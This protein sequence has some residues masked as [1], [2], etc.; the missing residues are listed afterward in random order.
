MDEKIKLAVLDHNCNINI[1]Q[2]V[3]SKEEDSWKKGNIIPV[4]KKEIKKKNYT[5]KHTE[6]IKKPLTM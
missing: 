2:A 5:I 4:H 1:D 3:F 6:S